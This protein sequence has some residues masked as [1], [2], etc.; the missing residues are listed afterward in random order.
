MHLNFYRGITSRAP[1]H[2]HQFALNDSGMARCKADF[3][4]LAA[5]PTMVE[6]LA[7]AAATTSLTV[8][9]L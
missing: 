4:E 5:A 7:P 6:K 2:T 8:Y 3:A 9:K 1:E